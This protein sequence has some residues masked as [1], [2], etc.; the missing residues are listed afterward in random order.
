MSED[1]NPERLVTRAEI[2]ELA[3]LFD[4]SEFAFDPLSTAAKE[5]ESDFE[6]KLKQIFDERVAPQYASVDFATFHCRVRSLCRIYLK[7]NAP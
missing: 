3:L 1:P 5:A 4:R 6:A 7:R 2:A